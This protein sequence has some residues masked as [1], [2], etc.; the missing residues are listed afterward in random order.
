MTNE[1]KILAKLDELSEAVADA[2]RAVRPMSDL[3]ADME[4][5]VRQL[6]DEAIGKLGGVDVDVDDVGRLIGSTLGSAGNLAE[7]VKTL[8]AL[9][10]LKK[11]MVP[12]SKQAFNEAI[13]GLDSVGHG[14]ELDDLFMLLRQTV[15][16]LGNL[17]EGLKTLNAA[18][19]FKSDAGE[20][21][22]QA[23]DMAIE[24]LDQLGRAGVFEGLGKL[25]QVGQKMTA[26]AADLDF[27]KAKPITGLFGMLGALKD[28]QVQKGLGVAMQLA[29]LL[30]AV[31]ED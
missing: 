2:R 8:N 12:I 25:A 21:S 20:I 22:K 4:P 1:E 13:N 10:D 17:A 28:P 6:V 5:V 26:A 15:L 3:K 23:M 18:M 14:F 7:G 16:N 19:E 11:D 27:S 31:A 9:L 30:G 24:Q 29:G